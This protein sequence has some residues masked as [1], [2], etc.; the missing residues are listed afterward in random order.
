LELTLSN[1]QVLCEDC[2]LGKSNT[3]AT[4]WRVPNENDENVLSL[5]KIVW[6]TV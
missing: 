3:D 4:D 1:L 2:N 5:D 6:R